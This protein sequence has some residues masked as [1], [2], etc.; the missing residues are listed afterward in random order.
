M[1]VSPRD[2]GPT[3]LRSTYAV[4]HDVWD[5]IG[6]FLSSGIAGSEFTPLKLLTVI[7]LTW[8]LVWVTRR[9][10]RWFVETALARRGFDIGMRE[11]LGAMLRYGIIRWVLW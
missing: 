7:A 10:T 1:P 4:F 6:T 11:V 3:V 9:V 2:A 8:T 5:R